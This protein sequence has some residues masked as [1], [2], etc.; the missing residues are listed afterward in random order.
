M[1]K[2][3]IIITVF[4]IS[5]NQSEIKELHEEVLSL[6]LKNQEN[7]RTID[8]LTLELS[9]TKKNNLA[10]KHS[11]GVNVFLRNYKNYTL[12][13][14]SKYGEGNITNAR[15]LGNNLIVSY[16]YK[17]GKLDGIIERDGLYTGTY[18]TT[19]SSGT[20]SMKFTTD[21][22]ASGTWKTFLAGDAM[23]IRK[24]N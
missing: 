5:C 8:S 22:S 9:K 13:L 10:Q 17:Q 12:F 11:S 6:S 4:S 14:G 21:G 1:K 24:S 19:T 23:M 16:S 20:F 7:E 3:L 15:L 18:S 2:Y